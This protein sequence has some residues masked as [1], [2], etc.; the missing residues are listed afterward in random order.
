MQHAFFNLASPTEFA[1]LLQGFAPVGVEPVSLANAHNRVLAEDLLSPEDLP[2]APRSCMDGYA[3]RAADLFGASESNP[4]YLDCVAQIAI[5]KAP[6]FVLA[7]GQC[8]AIPTGGVLPQ[9]ADAVAMVE[10]AHE[11]GAGGVEFFK[12]LTPTENVMLQGED[13]AIGQL[14]L[15]RGR[16]LRSPEIGLLAGLGALR[17]TVHKTPRVAILSTGDELAPPEAAPKPGQVRDVNSLAL[18]CLVAEAQ[19]EP[20]P[21]GI[22]KDEFDSL[23][24]ALAQAL[25]RS[26]CV[27]ISGGSSI[28]LRDLT[29]QVLESLPESRILAHGVAISPGK[30]TILAE[31]AGKPVLGLPGQ[32]TSAQIVLLVFGQPLLRHLAG[33][34]NAFDPA[35]RPV[36]TAVLAQNLAS[37]PGREDYVR[38]RLEARENEPPLAW[39]LAGKS[40]L[41]KTLVQAHGL[42]RVPANREGLRSGA[43]LDVWML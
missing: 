25:E 21:L 7:P 24:A 17:F 8:A 31:V 15:E 41:L 43:P 19:A 34:T 23:R 22:V 40:G 3:V 27:L 29:V 28:G 1:E 11:L 39:P 6:E 36:R 37:K 16:R 30:P 13:A 10:H 32:V 14:A 42:I 20:I 4:G 9:G 33:E 38:V 12:S 2:P 5:D 18:A 35:R 26:D